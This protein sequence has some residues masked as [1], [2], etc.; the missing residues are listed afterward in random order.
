MFEDYGNGVTND[1]TL[2]EA[3]DIINEAKEMVNKEPVALS[4]KDKKADKKASKEARN[5]NEEIEIANMVMDELNKFSLPLYQAKVAAYTSVYNGG[6]RGLYEASMSDIISELSAARALPK[7]TKEEK[8]LRSFAIEIAQHKK[9]S[10]K[11]IDKNYKSFADF[12]EPDYSALDRIFDEEE[13]VETA[14]KD[15]YLKQS[16]ARK[17]KDYPLVKDYTDKIKALEAR[18]KELTDEEKAEMGKH[19]QFA[20]AAKPYLDAK[21]LMTEM[22][23]YK[24]LD[25]LEARYDEAKAN[26]EADLAAKIAEQKRL[27]E[28]KA[29][30]TKQ[31]REEKELAKAAKKENKKK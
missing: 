7:N 28:E 16:D 14:L 19:T 15:A 24:H 9:A 18:K 13:E 10:R 6:L 17:E 31:L 4:K 11:A 5:Y 8:E 29:A 26:A 30:R 27:E 1:R 3:I 20:Q 25:E 21:K 12:V 23:S 22:E 2:V